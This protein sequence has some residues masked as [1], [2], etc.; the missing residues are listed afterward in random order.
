M[1]VVN[2]HHVCAV[3]L[4]NMPIVIVIVLRKYEDRSKSRKKEL[5]NGC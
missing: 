1:R 2:M 5:D 3:L 4:L